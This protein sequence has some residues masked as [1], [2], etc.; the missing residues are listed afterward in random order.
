MVP[1]VAMTPQLL[2][3]LA[4]CEPTSTLVLPDPCLQSQPLVG[5]IAPQL[6]STIMAQ[7][8]KCLV[9]QQG[10]SSSRCS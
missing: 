2:Q 1:G 4:E 10:F 7:L 8:L 9:M 5:G 6:L 3:R